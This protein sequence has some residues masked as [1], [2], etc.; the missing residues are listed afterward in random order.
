[1][2]VPGNVQDLRPGLIGFAWADKRP[3]LLVPDLET[4]A[5]A[6]PVLAGYQ[7]ATFAGEPDWS[8]LTGTDLEPRDVKVDL[9]PANDK[10]SKAVMAEAARAIVTA[11]RD[12]G[13]TH[14]VRLVL[15]EGQP[16]G[17]SLRTAIADG[18]DAGRIIAWVRREDGR[19]LRDATTPTPTV[20]EIRAIEKAN[21]AQS[22][23]LQFREWGLDTNGPGGQP[24]CN[25]DTVDRILTWFD[26]PLWYDEFLQ[27]PMTSW[28]LDA[29]RGLT[30]G[31][32]VRL[33][34]WFQRTLRLPKMKLSTVRAGVDAYTFA[35]RRNC[36]V[37][38]LRGLEWDGIDRL[39]QLMPAGFGTLDTPY[40]RAVGRN[41]LM[42][43]ARRTLEPGCQVDN[44]P[45]LEGPQGVQK[46]SALRAIGGEWFTESHENVLSK[47]FLQVLPGHLLIEVA[48]MHSFKGAAMERVKGVIS[49]RVDTYRESYGRLAVPHPRMS[50]FAGTTNR[51][52]WNADDT[53]ARRFWRV[54]CGEIDVKWILVHRAQL[55]AEAVRRIDLGE[56]HWQVP[57]AEA[58][59]LVDAARPEDPWRQAIDQ[60]A[61]GRE[62]VTPVEILTHCIQM[63]PDR[64]DKESVARVRGILRGMGWQSGRVRIGGVQQ[65]AWVPPRGAAGPTPATP[66]PVDGF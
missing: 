4:R 25:E 33:A 22:Q 6:A 20:R 37:D 48:E 39:H 19:Y 2:P 61:F 51:D 1:M 12:A 44:M 46:S 23:H 27:R 18:W 35:H 49:N 38:W 65:R 47:D 66:D 28:L 10:S 17:W 40:Y 50:V 45:V 3:V 36:V 42:G 26:V 53:G 11:A 21:D 24:P 62:H 31:D 7:V 29:P 64:Q 30:D 34:V 5:M 58:R 13:A 52:D 63:P 60:Y 43:M 8:E 32:Y 9:W 55:F 54:L 14:R 16:D 57:D 59:A 56:P 15:P 41:F